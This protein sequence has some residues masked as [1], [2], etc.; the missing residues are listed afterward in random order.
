MPDDGA[1]RGG[2][3]FAAYPGVSRSSRS[4]SHDDLDVG[5]ASAGLGSSRR[6]LPAACPPEEV[7]KHASWSVHDGAA[8]ASH[9]REGAAHV[10]KEKLLLSLL[11]SGAWSIDFKPTAEPLVKTRYRLKA[12]G[13]RDDYVTRAPVKTR[14]AEA[15]DGTRAPDLPTSGADGPD[16]ALTLTDFAPIVE[17]KC[18]GVGQFGRIYE[19]AEKKG[20]RAVAIKML[21]GI[22]RGGTACGETPD[23][24]MA[25]GFAREVELLRDARLRHA[26]VVEYRGFGYIETKC[27]QLG[28]IALELLRGTDLRVLMLKRKLGVDEALTW[29]AQLASALDCLHACG[30]VHRDVKPSNCMIL[31]D[32]TLKLIDFGLAIRLEGGHA[33]T[34]KY[35]SSQRLGVPGFMPPEVY[36]C[37][38]YGAPVDVF[39]YGVVVHRMLW[40]AIPPGACVSMRASW[41]RTLQ[42]L[43][44]ETFYATTCSPVPLSAWPAR[45]AELVRRCCAPEPKMR[46]PAPELVR[47]TSAWRSSA[48]ASA[49]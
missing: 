10:P 24:H 40:N 31:G 20:G 42:E 41:T 6:S 2:S 15:P 1:L 27:G 21:K 48:A 39:A 11:A 49:V 16:G 43:M 18:I 32:G 4:L 12:E 7:R 46:P 36:R 13:E 5:C 29:A 33:A 22:V 30:V 3:A 47:L 26:N 38:P 9:I 44:P 34:T 14:P 8:F 28:F 45:T 25:E 37:E 23:A 35:Q 19:T 17:G